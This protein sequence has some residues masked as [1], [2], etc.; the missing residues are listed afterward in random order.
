MDKFSKYF[1]KFWPFLLFLVAFV[2]IFYKVF[3]LRL[4]PFPGDLLVSFFFPYNSGGWEG[5]TPWIT[6]KEFIAADVVRQLYP[7]RVLAMDMIKQGIIPLWNPYEIAGSPLI[8][9]LQSAV[10][11][12]LNFLFFILSNR[13]AWVTYILIQPIMSFCFMY[14]FIRSLK[15]SK[16]A[17]VLTGLAFPFSGFLLMQFEWGTVA[18]SISYLPLVLYGISEFGNTGKNKYLLIS[19]L[20]IACSLLAGYSQPSVYILIIAFVFYTYVFKKNFSKK[21]IILDSYFKNTW[22]VFLGLGL[23]AVQMLSVLRAYSFSARE[24]MVDTLFHQFQLPFQYLITFF[25]HD[26]FGNPATNN[27]WGKNYTEFT[28]FIGIVILFFGIVGIIF[29]W[30]N[31]L[32]KWMIGLSFFSLL[33]S[34]ANPI[35][36]LIVKYRIFV[37]STGVPARGIFLMQFSL[38]VIA[39]FGIDYFFKERK[40]KKYKLSLFFLIYFVIWVYVFLQANF[41]KNTIIL[42]NLQTI[43]RNLLIPTTISVLISILVLIREKFTKTKNLVFI[44]LFFVA[45]FEYQ[46]FINKFYPFS[47]INLL[48][49]ENRFMNTLKKIAGDNRI[50]GY[51]SAS[52]GSNLPTYW[53]L[54]FP[55]GFDSINL[56]RYGELI[57]STQKGH[58]D[59]NIPRSDANFAS[60]GPNNDSYPKQVVMNILNVSYVV[61]K[62]DNVSQN[63]E[64]DYDKFPR[65]RYELIWHDYKWQIYKNKKALSKATFFS[66][67]EKITDDSKIIDRLFS[68]EFPYR[69]KIIINDESVNFNH[70]NGNIEYKEIK[71]K[72]YSPTEIILEFDALSNGFVFLSDTN[73]PSWAAFDNDKKTNIYEA[74]YSFRA[75]HVTK[76]KHIIKFIYYPSFFLIGVIISSVSLGIFVLTG[77]ILFRKK[78]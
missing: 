48:Y 36:D 33:F 3:F 16:F 27:L 44:I 72:K 40:E 1:Y 28:T 7:W 8:G 51:D 19:S 55:E 34:T 62:N 67:Y 58:L 60:S 12:P 42:Y 10:F 77:F 49:P 32:V 75:I 59:R 68:K 24:S 78:T 37:L 13:A 38:L 18:H 61:N 47:P 5:Y 20:G 4:Y 31:L 69:E 39:A 9:N 6:H 11:Y 46:Y 29:C 65:D 41:F 74:D 54:Q 15:L 22:F 56:R 2:F 17:A 71:I 25:A 43:E 14:L 53:H 52:F 57:F 73:Y 70:I 76:G 35:S 21:R 26:F 45:V 64:P 23:S 50:Y 30:K 66:D 63:L